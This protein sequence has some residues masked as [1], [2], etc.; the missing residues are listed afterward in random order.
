M[1]FFD[2]SLDKNL[3]KRAADT[4]GGA[5]LEPFGALIPMSGFDA[6]YSLVQQFG[7]GN[8]YIPGVR[9]VF[10]G[11]LEKQMILEFDGGNSRELAF[12]YGFSERHVTKLLRRAYEER[13]GSA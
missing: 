3:I 10:G 13:K 6:V 4:H 1:N 7:G 2:K 9:K 8:I 11:C 12:K 5:V